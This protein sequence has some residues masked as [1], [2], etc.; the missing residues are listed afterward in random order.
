MF[1][2]SLNSFKLQYPECLLI[3]FAMQRQPKK[4]IGKIES[5][6]SEETQA[7]SN[8]RSTFKDCL[9]LY[10]SSDKVTTEYR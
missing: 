3:I 7:S 10:S 1:T 6:V 5:R 8:K 2:I 9:I 4:K